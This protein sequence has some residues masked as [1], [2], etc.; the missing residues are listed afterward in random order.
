MPQVP[1]HGSPDGQALWARI[2]AHP[3]ESPDDGIDLVRR[4]AR[5]QACTLSEARHAVEEYRRFAYLCCISAEELTPS[6][7]V[8]EVWHLHLLHSRDYWQHWCPEILRCPLHHGPTRGRRIDGERYRAQYARTLALYEQHFGAPPAAYWPGT[9]ERFAANARIRRV[10]LAHHIVLPRPRWPAA[11]TLGLAAAALVA[12]LIAPAVDALPA[13]PLDW[14]AGPFLTLYAALVVLALLASA[15]LRGSARDTGSGAAAPHDPLELAYLAGGPERCADAAVVQLLGDGRARW[16]EQAARLVLDAKPSG[17]G[18]HLDQVARCIL[19]D[20]RPGKVVARAR[21]GF[22]AIERSLH[23]RGLWLD[24]AQ[25]AR[26]RWLTALPALAVTL[27]GFGK[28]LIG[29]GRDK[30]IGFLIVMTIVMLLVVAVMA[31]S[32]P[33]RTRAGDRALKLARTRHARAARAPTQEE[34]PLAVALGGVAVLGAT[35]LAA[36][37]QAR[38][39]PS[40]GDGSS[41]DS[42]GNGDGGGGGGCGGCG[43]GD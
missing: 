25:L 9:R 43:G 42:D 17:H 20:G 31:A 37:A 26:A 1:V 16:D 23:G 34:W 4:F 28:M 6:L 32:T 18:E 19:L 41:S 40:S 8:D 30:P 29:V 5:E 36:Y 38:Q 15:W 22:S 21:D 35:P 3:F 13:N 7:R 24:R 2:A 11:A 27:F 39:P 33:A 10:D 12:T 14:T